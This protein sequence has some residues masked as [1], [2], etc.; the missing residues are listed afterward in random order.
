MQDIIFEV[1][2][3]KGEGTVIPFQS[4]EQ[5]TFEKTIQIYPK[6]IFKF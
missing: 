3:N 4:F 6:V 1:V 2:L 5:S